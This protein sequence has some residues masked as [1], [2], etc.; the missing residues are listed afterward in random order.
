M[1]MVQNTKVHYYSGK[2]MEANY[3]PLSKVGKKFLGVPATSSPVERVL[4][5]AGES[6]RADWC[7]ILPKNFE[8]LVFLKVNNAYNFEEFWLE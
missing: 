2:K 7:K 8:Q 5:Q 1:K 4:S 3:K 6:L